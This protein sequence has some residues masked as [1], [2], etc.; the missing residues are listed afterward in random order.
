[1]NP[2]SDCIMLTMRIDPW[3]SIYVYRSVTKLIPEK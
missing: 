2:P 3:V 1:M